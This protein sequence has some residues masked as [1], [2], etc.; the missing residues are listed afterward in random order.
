MTEAAL[1]QALADSFEEVLEKMFFIRSLGGPIN[2]SAAKPELAAELA[3]EGALHGRMALRVTLSSARSIA[4]DFLGEDEYA[5][6]ELQVTEVVCE[7]ANMICGSALSR[8]E[9][10][11]D[12]RLSSPRLLAPGEC[13]P[14]SRAVAHAAEVG[15]G[16]LEAILEMEGP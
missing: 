8:V 2:G 1:K 3:F 4:A 9:T 5:L 13:I 16:A 11:G 12:F 7:L 14:C 6:S 15:G 10:G